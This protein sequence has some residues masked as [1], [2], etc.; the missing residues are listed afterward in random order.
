LDP[1]VEARLQ[2]GFEDARKTRLNIG[3]IE[4]P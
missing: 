3:E 1:Q 4:V 2:V